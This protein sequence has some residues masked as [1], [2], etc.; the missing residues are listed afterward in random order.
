MESCPSE[1]LLVSKLIA[2][3]RNPL[4]RHRVKVYVFNTALLIFDLLHFTALRLSDIFHG[5]VSGKTVR[6]IL[7]T[8]VLSRGYMSA[9]QF[10]RFT[11]VNYVIVLALHCLVFR[12]SLTNSYPCITCFT[13]HCRDVIHL[14][15]PD[16]KAERR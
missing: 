2:L 13:Q 9:G 5:L 16:Q 1:Q 8:S 14:K 7:S 4:K 12:Y 10:P 15:L 3:T 6:C 11:C